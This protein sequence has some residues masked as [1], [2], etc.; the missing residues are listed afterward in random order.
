MPLSFTFEVQHFLGRMEAILRGLVVIPLS[1]SGVQ[2]LFDG[3]AVAL[4]DA[5]HAGPLG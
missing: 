3:V 1:G 4:R 2:L 5:L